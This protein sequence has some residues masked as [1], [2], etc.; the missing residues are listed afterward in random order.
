MRSGEPK[1]VVPFRLHNASHGLLSPEFLP[2]ALADGDLRERRGSILVAPR[3]LH[4]D[5]ARFE[6]PANPRLA[7]GSLR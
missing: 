5:G 3:R 7:A 4:W 6:M 1:V 2:L